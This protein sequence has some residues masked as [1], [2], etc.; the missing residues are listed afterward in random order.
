[1]KK[2]S[3]D[4]VAKLLEEALDH[5]ETSGKDEILN[6]I[7]VAESRTG[8]RLITITGGMLQNPENQAMLQALNSREAGGFVKNLTEVIKRGSEKFMEKFFVGYGHKSIGDCGVVPLWIDGLSMVA[9]KQFENWPLFSG[10]ETS[11]RYVDVTGVGWL[12]PLSLKKTFGNSAIKQFYEAFDWLFSFYKDALPKMKETVRARFPR[13]NESE[14]QYEN[15]VHAKTCDILGAYLPCGAKTNMSI[16]MNIR[17][18]GEHLQQMSFDPLPEVSWLAEDCMEFL[19]A[20]YPSSFPPKLYE[21]Q[22][23]YWKK[24]RKETAYFLTLENYPEYRFG[25]DLT[26][27][28]TVWKNWSWALKERPK[29]CELPKEMR[30]LGNCRVTHLQDYRSMRD[31]Y[32]HRDGTNRVPCAVMNFGM[33][34]W[35][36]KQMIF[37]EDLY[38]KSLNVLYK[39]EKF[40]SKNTKDCYRHTVW[41]FPFVSNKSTLL[42]FQYIVPMGYRQPCERT[43]TFP[44]TVYYVE[45]RTG[46]RVHPTERAVALKVTKS[47]REN[48]PGITLYVDESESEWDIKRGKDVIA[49]RY[50]SI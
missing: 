16:I 9:T 39:I 26:D 14:S 3:R 24:V 47:L 19:H 49:V 50:S 4:E 44:S 35:Y 43:L 25:H 34:D 5:T 2:L 20:I 15:A 41:G 7:H 23:E 22:A 10:Q 27:F 28:E 6:S 36:E 32:R 42:E 45:L 48:F 1:M 31:G 37:N 11:T 18:L 12:N 30:K 46:T 21:G 17:Q 13:E 38:R 33:E 8:A 29:G 40:Y